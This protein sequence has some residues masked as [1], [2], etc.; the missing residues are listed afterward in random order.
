MIDFPYWLQPLAGKLVLSYLWNV[1]S[2]ILLPNRL[3]KT[4]TT[5]GGNLGV[6]LGDYYIFFL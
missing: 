2:T 3:T 5:G 4:L 1:F 6:L